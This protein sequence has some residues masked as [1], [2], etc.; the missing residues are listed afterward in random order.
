MVKT[1]LFDL[2]GTLHY[3]RPSHDT[4][5]FD[6]AVRLGAQDSHEGRLKAIRWSHGYWAQSAELMADL[7]RFEGMEE[8][9]W[10][11]YARRRLEKFTCTAQQAAALAPG[12]Q[13]CMADEYRP[14]DYV[15]DEVPETLEALVRAGYVLGV[16]SN[17]PH[18]FDEQLGQLGLQ[19]FFRC[20]VAAGEVSS[21]KPEPEI[22][23]HALER[24][25]AKAEN[26]IYV[27]DNYYSDVVGAR[28][29]GIRPVLLDIEGIFPDSG[30]GDP[31][32]R[33]IRRISDIISLL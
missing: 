33:V 10:V 7:E 23:Y 25:G 13:R 3:N 11:N 19:R 29:A 30:C 21:W 15:P 16:V 9:F 31:Q 8:D 4:A 22:F 1:I 32:A 17:R 18:S 14:E 20:T 24:L 2:D 12:V 6:F 26:S 5:F 27:G 28:R